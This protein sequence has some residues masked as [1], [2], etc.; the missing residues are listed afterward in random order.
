M[1][2]SQFHFHRHNLQLVALVP[3]NSTTLFVC[4]SLLPSN[5]YYLSHALASIYRS[6]WSSKILSH[7]AG[8]IKLKFWTDVSWFSFLFLYL[9]RP[10]LVLGMHHVPL[11]RP[12]SLSAIALRYVKLLNVFHFF[13]VNHNVLP[14]SSTISPYC[15][16]FSRIKFA[17]YSGC[18]LGQSFS[19]LVHSL[20]L[21]DSGAMSSAKS[22]GPPALLSDSTLSLLSALPFSWPSPRQ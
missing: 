13:T 15:L 18:F 20:N 14:A 8:P 12:P 2:P 11:L 6:R 4:Y 17:C 22:Q 7:I 5:R 9:L 1:W 3:A 21:D 19:L 10:S 16:A